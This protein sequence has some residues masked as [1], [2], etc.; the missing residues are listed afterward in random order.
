[1][2]LLG[3]KGGGKMVR[4]V[5]KMKKT[6]EKPRKYMRDVGQHWMEILSVWECGWDEVERARGAVCGW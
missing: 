1:M 4:V 6:D 5:G 2:N 3:E